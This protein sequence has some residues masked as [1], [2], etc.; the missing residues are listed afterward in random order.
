MSRVK[1]SDEENPWKKKGERIVYDNP[2]IQVTEHQVID[3]SGN[4]TIYGVVSPK[5]LAIGI[6][7]LDED[8]NTWLIGQYR[9]P[10]QRYS[11]EIVEGGAPFGE[12][13]I[14]AARRE[15]KEEAGLEAEEWI[16][17]M[18]MS[19]SNCLADE[20][21]LFYVA[22][23]LTIGEPKP[24]DNEKLQLVKLPF[25]EAYQLVMEG[26]IQDSMSVAAI[27]K[28]KVLMDEGKI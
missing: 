26:R 23:N 11:W 15:L 18:E 16:Y 19:T 7:P 13:P 3:P 25:I 27:L 5:H 22:R 8:N 20:Q 2:W 17:F 10:L 24:D 9:Y 12:D 21:A 14:N 28:L 6:I 1:L 4:D